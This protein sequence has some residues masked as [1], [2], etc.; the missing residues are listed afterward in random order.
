MSV[1]ANCSRGKHLSEERCSLPPNGTQRRTL[2]LP[3]TQCRFVSARAARYPR[4]HYWLRTAMAQCFVFVKDSGKREQTSAETKTAGNR[5]AM[6]SRL[7]PQG[8]GTHCLPSPHDREPGRHDLA[9]FL[10]A[11]L[12]RFRL[13]GRCHGDQRSAG[14]PRVS[15]AI[16][17][18]LEAGFLPA[19]WCGSRTHCLR[20]INP[21]LYLLS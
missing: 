18:Q 5:V 17:N 2:H 13:A 14:R 15:G 8:R 21:S 11:K 10:S 3:T 7:F 19:D 1:F 12:F 4:F 16:R 9:R 6:I 20:V